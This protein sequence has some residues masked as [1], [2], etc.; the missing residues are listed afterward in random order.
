[1]YIILSSLSSNSNFLRQIFKVTDN[2]WLFFSANS[3]GFMKEINPGCI[4]SSSLALFSTNSRINHHHHHLP[5]SLWSVAMF[6]HLLIL[7]SLIRSH[8]YMLNLSECGYIWGSPLWALELSIWLPMFL[9]LDFAYLAIPI[10][11]NWT[12]LICPL[13]MIT[14]Y[15]LYLLYF[16]L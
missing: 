11:P 12:W 13:P 1:M 15:L 7:G 5:R 2:F 3:D 16:P 10:Y 14:C 8:A 4:S 9:G 6:P